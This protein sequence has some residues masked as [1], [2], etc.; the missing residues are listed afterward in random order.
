MMRTKTCLYAHKVTLL[1]APTAILS[2]LISQVCFGAILAAL[3]DKGI[4]QILEAGMSFPK[5]KRLSVG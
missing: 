1:S 3:A 4:V 2:A 5:N